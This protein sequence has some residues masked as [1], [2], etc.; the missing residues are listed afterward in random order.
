MKSTKNSSKAK[1]VSEARLHAKWFPAYGI[2]FKERPEL[3]VLGSTEEEALKNLARFKFYELRDK[4]V[5]NK[6]EFVNEPFIID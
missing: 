4:H 2:R 5:D 1:V 6:V 3:V